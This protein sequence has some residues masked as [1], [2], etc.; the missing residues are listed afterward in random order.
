M[1]EII[2]VASNVAPFATRLA[3]AGVK[4]VI[5]Y[6]NQRNSTT[7]P[8]KCLTRAELGSCTLLACLSPSSSNSA[9]G[10]TAIW[11]TSTLA[12]APRTRCVRSTSPPT[13]VS[14]EGSAIY[15][16]VDWDYFRQSEL[17]Q[18]TPY[19]GRVKDTLDGKYLVG[20][21]GS[22]TIGR[23]LKNLGLVD[24]HLACRRHRVVRHPA[25]LD[26][27]QLEHVSKIRGERSDIGGFIYDG[28][29]LRHSGHPN[30]LT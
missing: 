24:L 12:V 22:G 6:Y 21:Y 1:H 20:V 16:A 17:N 25:R 11:K 23:H 13:L 8:T 5:R 4:A 10:P 9:V 26:R 14:R 2:D 7:F 19:F 18:I 30:S 15:F 27:G 3:E 28:N 29:V